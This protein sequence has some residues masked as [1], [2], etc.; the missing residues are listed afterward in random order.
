M[1]CPK[2]NNEI[3]NGSLFCNLCGRKIELKKYG[4]NTDG[5]DREIRSQNN[6]EISLQY[7]MLPVIIALHALLFA[8][9]VGL[10]EFKDVSKGYSLAII[11]FGILV[12][13]SSIATY[14]HSE[15]K[16][17][18]N[19]YF[20][21]AY[22]KRIDKTYFDFPPVWGWYNDEEKIPKEWYDYVEPFT[23]SCFRKV[24]SHLII[25]KSLSLMFLVLWI[26]IFVIFII[27]K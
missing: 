13:V 3:P 27:T 1:D 9:F 15:T 16:I 22:L 20:W 2:C 7:K 4:Y 6:F 26:A 11:V 18:R 25:L 23:V 5:Y 24:C 8:A 12:S 21:N 19:M 14:F 17:Q 10:C